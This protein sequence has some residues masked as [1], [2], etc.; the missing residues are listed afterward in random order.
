MH[1]FW[2]RVVSFAVLAMAL[3]AGSAH[4]QAVQPAPSPTLRRLSIEELARIDVTSVSKHAEPVAEAAAAISVLT[5]NDL[6][7]A[8]V[9]S[10]PE[11][12][13]L[14]TGM[15]VG[16]FDNHTWAASPRGF[17]ISTANKLAVFI[18]GRSVYTPFFSGVFWDV[19]DYVLDDIE[20]IEVI[21]GPGGTLWGANAVNGVINII[22]KST[23][24]TLGGLWKTGGG[25][26]LGQMSVRHGGS[27][28]DRGAFRVYGKYRYRAAQVFPTGEN[29]HD[30]FRQGQI[31]FRADF[32]K[33]SRTAITAQGDYYRAKVGISDRKDSDASGGNSVVRVV[34]TFASGT[35]LQVQTYYDHTWRTVPRQYAER[36]DTLDADAQVRFSVGRRHDFLAGGGYRVSRGVVTPSAI[37]VFDPATR[38]NLLYSAFV[39]DDVTIVPD[40][41]NVTIGSKFEHNDYTGFEYQPTIRARW[42]LHSAQTV[43]GAVSR[44]VRMPTRFDTDLRVNT[45]LPSGLSVVVL[46]GDPGFMSEEMLSR[47]IGFRRQLGGRVS[48]DIAA[49]A[50][51]YDHLRTQEPTPPAVIPIVLRNKLAA[52]TR[53]IET[54]A[55]IQ[56][57]SAL[58]LFAGYSFLSA[59]FTPAPDS[60][61]PSRGDGE[62]NDPR[63]QAW[64]RA[65]YNLTDRVEIDGVVR[66]VSK[67]PQP[68]VPAYAELTLHFGWTDRSGRFE[69][70]VV[71]DNLLHD[72]HP[73]F[74]GLN[75]RPEYR[76]NFL[77]Q[78]LWKF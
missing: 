16:R 41:L 33:S 75:P 64:F 26:D 74:G 1:A 38:T 60:R 78:T 42:R 67:L 47:E 66:V 59:S 19:Q 24:D 71:G 65:F 56:A 6:R 2:W 15:A 31:G 73:E 8:G 70:Q 58:H 23:H 35:Q 7:R 18:D 29:T 28:G 22:T 53:G 14:V 30:P 27:M 5:Q 52:R 54:T 63:H 10:L 44:A 11:A 57:S 51:R 46:R 39:Q 36:R 43:W 20:R 32:S 34:H 77:I 62:H 12:L 37:F 49:F 3:G 48:L 55:E 13:R 61:D 9:T 45:V 50:N 69:L 72:H 76:R 68:V 40:R 17:N 4:A 21:R 25:N